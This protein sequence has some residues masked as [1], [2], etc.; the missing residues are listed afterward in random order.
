M[1]QQPS[2]GIAMTAPTQGQQEQGAQ[3][4]LPVPY[5]GNAQEGNQQGQMQLVPF[6]QQMQLALPG[7]QAETVYVAPMYTKPRPIIPR[8]RIF[9]GIL[10]ILI[11]ALLVCGR[12]LLSAIKWVVY[13]DWA[14]DRYGAPTQYRCSCGTKNTRSSCG[15]RGFRSGDRYYSCRYHYNV[16]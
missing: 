4:L 10:S 3:S 14:F 16:Y 8:Y 13:K 7:E 5:T 1:S 15:I 9:S 6:Q 12:S 11:V 2:W